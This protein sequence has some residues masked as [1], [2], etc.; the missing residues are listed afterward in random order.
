[1][2]MGYF[3]G[4]ALILL[5]TVTQVTGC[6]GR[7]ASP[8]GAVPRAEAPRAEAVATRPSTLRMVPQTGHL[9]IVSSASTTS[10][11][12][13]MVTAGGASIKVWDVAT[14]MLVR[15]IVE[16]DSVEQALL[17]PGGRR[18]LVRLSAGNHRVGD[19]TKAELLRMWDIETGQRAG[20]LRGYRAAPERV[21]LVA[22]GAR[23][24]ALTE[25]ARL[26][27]WDTASGA[28]VADVAMPRREVAL[29]ATVESG[30]LLTSS[31]DNL[32]QP[33]YA[34]PGGHPAHPAKV[35]VRDARTG[36]ALRALEPLGVV[37]VQGLALSRD[38]KRAVGV[39]LPPGGYPR[40]GA[41][42][43]WDVESGRVL[44]QAPGY[45]DRL[46]FS[47]DGRRLLV[48]GNLDGLRYELRDA[49]SLAP[50]PSFAWRL[51]RFDHLGDADFTRDGGSL[52][53]AYGR[54]IGFFDPT[55][56]ALQAALP[57]NINGVSALLTSPDGARLH[58]AQDD[59]TLRRW[60]LRSG[61]LDRATRL[62]F[63][64]R[65]MTPIG[66]GRSALVEPASDDPRASVVVWD[67]EA[68]RT[69]R[70][71]PGV[72]AVHGVSR[73]GRLA[74]LGRSDGRHVLRDL[75]TGAEL[76]TL[77]TSVQGVFPPPSLGT[78]AFSPDGRTF[79]GLGTGRL[80]VFDLATG[81]R[82]IVNA[83][84]GRSFDMA[85]SADGR[86]LATCGNGSAA[87]ESVTLWDTATLTAVRT[88]TLDHDVMHVAF[89]AD[90]ARLA[91][92]GTM[93][94]GPGRPVHVWSVTSGELVRAIAP[95]GEQVTS[96]AFSP[97][98]RLVFLG[99][100]H[101]ATAVN[102]RTGEAVTLAAVADQWLAYA[103]DGTFDASRSAASIVAAADGLRPF[104]IEQFA[105]RNNR[106][107]VLL[108]RLGTG[109]PEAIAYFKARAERRL[110]TLGVATSAA[111]GVIAPVARI[112]DV[113]S[114]GASAR[115]T[116][117]L[118]SEPGAPE[119]LRY[120]VQ[121]N[122]VP[123]LGAL[124]KPVAAAGATHRLVETIAL[125]AGT[126]KIEVSAFDRAGVESLRDVRV[127]ER[128]APPG[129]RGDLW[130]LGF[131]VS[132]YRD[133]ALNLDF[134]EKDAKDLAAS[135][136]RARGVGF[137]DVHVATYVDEEVTVARLREAK[138]F[139]ASAKVD[140]VAVVFVAGHG[141]H[142]RDAAADYFFVTH[143][144]DVRRLRDTAAPFSLVEGLLEGIQPR[145]KLLFLDT[146]ESGERDVDWA[147][148]AATAGQKARATRA[149]VLAAAGT[150]AAPVAGARAR[151]RP[152]LL[153]RDRL[154]DHDLSRRSGALVF[155]ASR[156]DELSWEDDSLQNGVFTSALRAALET[157][158]ADADR[159]G[160]VSLDELRAF[161]TRTVAARTGDKQHPSVDHDNLALRVGW[162][163]P[164]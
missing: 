126:N 125:G 80:F 18:V 1:M 98:G 4:L 115:L 129:P 133:P 156:G 93:F 26:L 9:A 42:V 113:A 123:V 118:T 28:L 90:G 154:I 51:G 131:G 64:A 54:T 112:T 41:L 37:N 12:R 143:D 100:I 85:L 43:L 36:N 79:Y 21:A 147:P 96:L 134:A 3:R 70:A 140:D 120:N 146:C 77:D 130:F 50:V 138:A 104:R 99:G 78:G 71:L 31:M 119:I 61:A 106:P 23:A 63:G 151:A 22:G 161:V 122:D 103:G 19:P 39:V 7:P 75:Q 6:G 149:L 56:G 29:G 44:R 38:G 142:S 128:P 139:F 74:V 124:G 95:Q 121:V 153:A 48:W 84:A 81:A 59:W 25:D 53:T 49:E 82:R 94:G 107:D 158:A 32:R 10:D 72:S 87:T 101:G 76:R 45:G 14:R 117:E 47:P 57:S 136:A 83:H 116:L 145:R 150:G 55:T 91:A 27:G 46:R 52:V 105:A 141:T 109:D 97:D 137:A 67:V 159:D 92:G 24:V 15:T 35:T 66:D 68:S 69:L 73:D 163:T 40:D 13:F 114:D 127:I 162:P 88:H 2:G 17:L 58:V 155:A 148:A 102:L 65:R 164:R 110:R 34:P 152:W 62:P 8:R 89:S 108:E 160:Q 33:G 111:V 157:T 16:D 144:V 5:L 30:L 11:G 60:D 135:F 20:S 132:K 86:R